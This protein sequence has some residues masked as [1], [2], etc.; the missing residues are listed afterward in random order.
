MAKNKLEKPTI[1]QTGF[2]SPAGDYLESRIDLNAELIER[3]SSTF[4]FRSA[5]CVSHPAGVYKGDVFVVDRAAMPENDDLL[6]VA[7][8]GELLLRR[9]V[10]QQ[11]K[12][13]LASAHG[14]RAQAMPADEDVNIWGVVTYVIHSTRKGRPA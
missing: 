7:W 3:P 8:H 9:L 4:F 14:G 13:F 1:T 11:G 10:I 12:F 2:Q 6:I 5:A